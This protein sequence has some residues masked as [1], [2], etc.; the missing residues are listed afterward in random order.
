MQSNA[1]CASPATVVS[2]TIKV[3]ISPLLTPTASISL[4]DSTV[5]EGK[6][7]EFI[8]NAKNAGS[9]PKYEWQLNGVVVGKDS[10]RYILLEP[11]TGDKVNCL[12]TSTES[13]KSLNSVATP[14][15]T[16]EVFPIYN[17]NIEV[18]DPFL[19]DD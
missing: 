5:C 7:V 9:P 17:L 19:L 13:C 6:A 16:I 11:K 10:S 4:D 1:T 2:N 8:T 12:V 14:T 3:T 15:K 18:P